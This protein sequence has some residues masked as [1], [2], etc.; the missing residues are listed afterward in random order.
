MMLTWTPYQDS[1]DAD[2]FKFF[3]MCY[4]VR[5]V[6]IKTCMV[7]N[8]K[9]IYITYKHTVRY[10]EKSHKMFKE[11]WSYIYLPNWKETFWIQVFL[12][13]LMSHR[14]IHEPET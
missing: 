14:K 1:T 9:F 2:I 6:L 7:Q 11:M 8:I 10:K 3:K 5:T 4:I 12:S 13:N